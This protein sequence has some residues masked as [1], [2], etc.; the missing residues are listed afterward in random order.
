M[1]STFAKLIDCRKRIIVPWRTPGLKT[2]IWT[3][4]MHEFIIQ[5]FQSRH[6]GALEYA[7]PCMCLSAKLNSVQPSVSSENEPTQMNRICRPEKQ[8]SQLSIVANESW[9]SP[10]A[11]KIDRYA[12]KTAIN[13]LRLFLSFSFT[14]WL[15]KCLCCTSRAWE[16][17]VNQSNTWQTNY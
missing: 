12:S 13:L 14:H 11:V 8:C 2:A 15:E 1:L 6:N 3:Q 9:K 10:P 17:S 16:E 4:T 7:Q 5:K